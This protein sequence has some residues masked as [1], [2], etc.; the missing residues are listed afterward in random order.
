[1]NSSENL[2]RGHGDV[3]KQKIEVFALVSS[4]HFSRILKVAATMIPEKC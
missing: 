4:V 3:A 1:M 2:H